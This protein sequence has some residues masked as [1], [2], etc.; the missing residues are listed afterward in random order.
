MNLPGQ[1]VYSSNNH[2]LPH[3]AAGSMTVNISPLQAGL[4]F[5]KINGVYV[6]KL[7]RD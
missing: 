3:N 7:V 1:V 5:V 4:Y 2:I 6:R